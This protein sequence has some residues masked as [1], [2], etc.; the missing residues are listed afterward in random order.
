MGYR[1]NIS[2]QVKTFMFHTTYN[3]NNSQSMS[4]LT[5]QSYIFDNQDEIWIVTFGKYGK[6][7][8]A[9]GDC[10][11]A[12]QKQDGQVLRIWFGEKVGYYVK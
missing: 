10:S 3:E 6:E 5:P 7:N 1:Y 12:I 2:P 9:G 11:I 8:V 4:D